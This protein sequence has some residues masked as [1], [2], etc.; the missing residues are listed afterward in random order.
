M[1]PYLTF[2]LAMCLITIL[3]LA[4]TSYM[5]VYFNRRAKA[6]LEAAL[7]PLAQVI[8]GSFDLDEATIEGRYG[9]HLAEAAV[10]LRP[11]GMG[12]VFSLR[13]FDGAGGT[14]WQWTLTRSKDPTEPAEDSYTGASPTL[15]DE[16]DGHLDQLRF[17][18]A[19]AEVWFKVEYDPEAGHV[20]LTR[21]MKTRRDIPDRDAF[22]RYLHALT[23]IA[24]GNRTI[25]QSEGATS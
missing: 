2:G 3:A 15:V 12:R 17:D 10:V 25:Q 9:D 20:M 21:P 13:M 11:G 18:P 4:G 24:N 14:P 23:D 19:L 1:N 8:D 5:A 16:L 6:D 7:T 22:G